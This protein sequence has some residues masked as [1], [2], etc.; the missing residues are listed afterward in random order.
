LGRKRT[1]LIGYKMGLITIVKD[2]KKNGQRKFVLKCDKCESEKEV[3]Y[4]QYASGNWNV[5]EHD[6]S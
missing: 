5:C 3:W 2:F 1:E 6:A 4:S